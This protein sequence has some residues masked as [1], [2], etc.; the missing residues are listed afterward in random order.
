MMDSPVQLHLQ[1]RERERVK[2]KIVV[3]LNLL[4]GGIFLIS[5]PVFTFTE[6]QPT[7]AKLKLN[8][9]LISNWI[10]AIGWK[11]SHAYAADA[12][13]VAGRSKHRPKC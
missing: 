6:L 7:G 4:A 11:A 1:L 9:P 10:A 5:G 2:A 8:W 3:S 12:T 13:G